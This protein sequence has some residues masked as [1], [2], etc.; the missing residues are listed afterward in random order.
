MYPCRERTCTDGHRYLKLI[1]RVSRHDAFPRFPSSDELCF[2]WLLTSQQVTFKMLRMQISLVAVWAWEFSIGILGRNGRAFTGS[3]NS[4]RDRGHTTRDTGENSPST[5]RPNYLAAR[6][7]LCSIWRCTI[8]SCNWVR[9]YP[10]SLAI[11]VAERA[12]WQPVKVRTAVTRRSRRN[13][14]RVGLSIGG[15][16]QNAMMRRICRRRLSRGLRMGKERRRR[17]ATHGGMR[18]H[19]RSSRRRVD[20]MSSCR[21]SRQIR[22]VRLSHVGMRRR[23]RT[24]MRLQRWQSMRLRHWILWLHRV[25]RHGHSRD[26]SRG[27]RGGALRKAGRWRPRRVGSWIHCGG[28]GVEGGGGGEGEERKG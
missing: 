20:I 12:R 22:S 3:V 19:H 15:R 7:L 18:R 26:R 28:G 21:K 13:G 9:V 1:E 10:S 11:R 14:L 16:R 6:W 27:Q 24:V 17:Q 2:F 4:I 23:R 8:C 5:L 25:L